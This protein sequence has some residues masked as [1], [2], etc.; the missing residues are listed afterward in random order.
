MIFIPYLCISISEYIYIFIFRST[1]RCLEIE[2][3]S[4][5]PTLTKYF[6]N[7]LQIYSNTNF[8]GYI[9]NLLTTRYLQIIKEK[10]EFLSKDYLYRE[11]EAER[12][13]EGDDVL[14]KELMFNIIQ[15][16]RQRKISYIQNYTKFNEGKRAIEE[17]FGVMHQSL[18][19]GDIG[20][21]ISKLDNKTY[22]TELT[23]VNIIYCNIVAQ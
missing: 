6:A 21:Y 16:F 4:F 23:Y 20:K 10:L 9:T 1:I 17:F 3:L 12:N 15:E 8:L 7:S 18:D 19:A 2:T 14:I 22:G 11:R 5:S 13:M